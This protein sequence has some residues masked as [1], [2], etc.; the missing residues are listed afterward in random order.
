VIDTTGAGDAFNGAFTTS[1]I[2]GIDPVT[3]AT[4][5]NAA[6][7]IKCT[8]LGARTCLPTMKE[9]SKF[10]EDQGVKNVRLP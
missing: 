10:L 9:V 1:I 7:A 3:A 8:G 6:A 2:K 5:A 4:F